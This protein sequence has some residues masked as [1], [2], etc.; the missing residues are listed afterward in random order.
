MVGNATTSSTASP[1]FLGGT[2][3]KKLL[4]QGHSMLLLLCNSIHM[5]Q[6]KLRDTAILIVLTVL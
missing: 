5:N 3:V 1:P 6:V 4:Q 2:E